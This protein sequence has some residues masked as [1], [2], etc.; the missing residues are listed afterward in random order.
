MKELVDC[1]LT[2][3]LSSLKNI[4]IRLW[5]PSLFIPTQQT[6][7]IFKNPERSNR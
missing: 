3:I 1:S 6:S 5:V 4:V 2:Q 7:R